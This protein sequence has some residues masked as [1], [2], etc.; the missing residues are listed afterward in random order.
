MLITILC[1]P[2]NA[3]ENECYE[4]LSD[5]KINFQQYSTKFTQFIG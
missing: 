2:N 5:I 4:Q 1:T 3:K